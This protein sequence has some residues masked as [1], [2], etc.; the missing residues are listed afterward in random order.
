MGPSTAGGAEEGR[1][2]W[3]QALT[4]RNAHASITGAPSQERSRERGRFEGAEAKKASMLTDRAPVVRRH[5]NYSGRRPLQG[6]KGHPGLQQGQHVAGKELRRETE[7][8][9]VRVGC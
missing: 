5:Y 8:V 3:G 4:L 7:Q 1:P 6:R 2:G 9:I